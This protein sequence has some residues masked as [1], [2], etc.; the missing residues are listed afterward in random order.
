MAKK[1]KNESLMKFLTVI[2]GLVALASQ[3]FALLNYSWPLGRYVG[4]YDPVYAI[5]GL[6]ISVITIY[7]AIKPNAPFP[8]HWLFLFVLG[9][10]LIVFAGGIIA[11]AL[12]IIAALIGLIEQL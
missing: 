9:I 6:I 1:Y 11:C 10:L 8:F 7:T 12:L 5:I 2:G 3:I 4:F